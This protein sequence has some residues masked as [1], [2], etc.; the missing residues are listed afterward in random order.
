MKLPDTWHLDIIK[1]KVGNQIILPQIQIY[2]WPL[3]MKMFGSLEVLK[4]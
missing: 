3:K 2:H 4:D 1:Y